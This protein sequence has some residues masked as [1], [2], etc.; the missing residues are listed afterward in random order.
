MAF[1][2]S[3]LG[4]L[5]FGAMGLS[6]VS[7]VS[8]NLS[9]ST[10]DLETA[11]AFYVADGG[12]QY[13]IMK[14]LN[15]DSNFSDNVSPTGAPFGGTP[16]SFNPGQFWIEYSNQSQ[17]GI[18]VK[19]TGKVGNSVRVVRWTIDRSGSGYK[20]GTM[21]GGNFIA[22][23]STSTGD[24]YG[25]AGISGNINLGTNVV[26]HGTLAQDPTLV[27]P[28]IDSLVYKNMCT[29]TV[30]G[31][32][33]VSSNYSGNLC[34]LGGNVTFS[35]NLTYTGLLYT[36]GNITFNGN[37]LTVNGTIVAEGSVDGSKGGAGLNH[38]QFNA[39]PSADGTYMPAILGNG[40][41]FTFQKAQNMT[42]HGVLWNPHNPMN[43]KQMNNLDLTG[44]FIAG[45][46]VDLSSSTHM[47]ITFDW[48]YL[49]GIPGLSGG[50]HT[51]TSLGVNGWKAY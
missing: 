19:V 11:Q 20:D 18:D 38:L 49:V 22:S 51:L 6:L 15:G 8:D 12:M 2:A 33:T 25:N 35:G 43:M 9:G 41:T 47:K 30:S 46:N 28:S 4:M 39:Q 44:S 36:N 37:N 32:Y 45:G 21:M 7:V 26:V 1:I 13:T 42:V 24:I 3:V 27:P 50:S 23:A 31:N 40:S 16:V 29:T 5:L 14:E 34:V 17:N 48:D 10:D